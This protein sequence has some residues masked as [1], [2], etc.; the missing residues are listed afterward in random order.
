MTGNWVDK[1]NRKDRF[2][3]MSAKICDEHSGATQVTCFAGFGYCFL[4]ITGPCRK[5]STLALLSLIDEALP[6]KSV[7]GGIDSKQ[8]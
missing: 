5:L 7:A 2:P 4:R 6:M 3:G 1:Q 8:M